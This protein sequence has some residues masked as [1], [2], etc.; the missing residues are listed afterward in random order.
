VMFTKDLDVG[1]IAS[2]EVIHRSLAG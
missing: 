1:L 2:A